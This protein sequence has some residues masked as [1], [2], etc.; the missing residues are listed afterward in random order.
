LSRVTETSEDEAT[1]RSNAPPFRTLLAGT[2]L[3]VAVLS[4]AG[5]SYRW[6]YYYNFGLQSLVLT[7]PLSSLPM[8]ATEIVRN[9][10]SWIDLI[11]Y[12]LEF[13]L[14]VSLFAWAI[15]SSRRASRLWIRRVAEVIARLLALDTRW[16]YEAIIAALIVLIAFR[17]GGAAGYRTYLSNVIE[18]ERAISPLPRVTVIASSSSNPLLLGARCDTRPLE[19]RTQSVPPTF[20]GSAEVAQDLT[21]GNA[22]SSSSGSW[23]LLLRDGKNLYLF[24]TVADPRVR[25]ET[26]VLPDGPQLMLVLQ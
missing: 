24:R 19:Q 17:V 4:V 23:R 10:R 2:S 8:Y 26:L 14:P 16:T 20:I 22:C 21:A 13:L 9:P 5:Y 25:P 6:T 15:D 7:A 11:R 3:I 1:S 18:A 12:S